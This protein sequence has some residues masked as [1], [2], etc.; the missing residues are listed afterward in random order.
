MSDQSTAALLERPGSVVDAALLDVPLGSPTRPLWRGRL[1]VVALGCAVP[2]LVLLAVAAAGTAARVGAILYGIGLCTMLAV[3]ATYH[4]WVHTVQARR[5]W[6]RADHAAIYAAIAGTFVPVCLVLG[7]A[8]SHAVLGV[9]VVLS[10]TG[11]AL[12]LTGRQSLDRIGAGLYVGI[13]WLGILL[14]PAIG[15]RDG[16]A[17]LALLTAGGVVYTVGALGFAR[18]WPRLSPSVF[19]YH[20]VWHAATITAAALQFA[21][22]WI[23]VA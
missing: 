10:A 23:I 16:L 11:A 2:P 14:V 21:A 17:P 6:R 19:S 9:V 8:F 12:K 1:H 13:G 4:R 15:V 3:S 22:V 5:I 20:E 18:Q 7:T